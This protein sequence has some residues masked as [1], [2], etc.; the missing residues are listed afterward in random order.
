MRELCGNDPADR[1]LRT[2]GVLERRI[3]PGTTVYPDSFTSFTAPEYAALRVMLA[4]ASAVTVTLCM[5]G[6]AGAGAQ[7]DSMRDTVRRL[8]RLCADVG[9]DSCDSV[10]PDDG[11]TAASE[12]R[13]LG[14]GLWRF[15]IQPEA[16][17][18]PT[19]TAG[20]QYVRSPPARC[21]AKP[22][23]PHCISESC[24]MR[25]FRMGR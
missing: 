5:K 9:T 6:R 18:I 1:L 13:I 3:F 4:Q 12:L 19:K 23:P 14:D 21:T 8:E 10:L 16:R 7:F 2:A 11:C 22:A 20:G 25:G 15:G 24:G 17:L